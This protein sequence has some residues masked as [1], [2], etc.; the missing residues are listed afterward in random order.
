MVEIKKQAKKKNI[1]SCL[2]RGET[3]K[4]LVLGLRVK[5][6]GR[7]HTSMFLQI[8]L[9][10]AH[11]PYMEFSIILEFTKFDGLV[12]FTLSLSLTIFFATTLQGR[13]KKYL[14]LLL[15]SHE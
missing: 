8:K 14:G 9:T 4:H 13:R 7:K 12:P 6:K 10:Q 2:S 11:H 3:E 1:L 15:Y 5:I